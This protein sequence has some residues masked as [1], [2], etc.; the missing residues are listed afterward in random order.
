[1]RASTFVF[2]LL[3]GI[4]GSTWM[5]IKVGLADVPPFAFVAARFMIATVVLGGIIALRRIPLPRTRRE[6]A[7]ILLTGALGIGGCYGLVYW[8]ELHIPSGLASVLSTTIPLF[9]LVFGHVLLKD[10]R[11][12]ARKL[13]GVLL[14]LGGVT[15]IFSGQLSASGA[16]AAWGT[17]AMLGSASSSALATVVVKRSVTHLSPVVLS[18]GQILVGTIL[19]TTVALAREGNPIAVRWTPRALGAL[20]YLAIVGTVIAFT[21]FYWLVRR[22]PVSRA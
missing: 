21:L 16:M 15:L 3:G 12:T 6:W 5:F 19:L 22:I 14:A 2:L 7:I 17:L 4:W 11:I 20:A 18:A 13:A 8:A 9:G 10:D 1:M